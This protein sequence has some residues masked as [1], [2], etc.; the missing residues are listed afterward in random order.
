MWIFEEI[1]TL[2]GITI[3]AGMTMKV[4]PRLCSILSATAFC[5]VM[6]GRERTSKEVVLMD[7]EIMAF[8]L[9][10]FKQAVATNA[11]DLPE[12][13]RATAGA[14]EVEQEINSPDFDASIRDNGTWYLFNMA[15]IIP[16]SLFRAHLER[17][18]TVVDKYVFE[19][20]G[21][22]HVA[23][24]GDRIW[25][26]ISESKKPETKAER[27]GRYQVEHKYYLENVLIPDI[28][29]HK[30]DFKADL[31]RHM[32]DAGKGQVIKDYT[33]SEDDAF[34]DVLRRVSPTRKDREY[35]YHCHNEISEVMY[36]LS[37]DILTYDV[38]HTILDECVKSIVG[39]KTFDPVTI[40]EGLFIAYQRTFVM[41]SE[42][43]DYFTEIKEHAP[44]PLHAGKKSDR[45]NTESFMYAV[46]AGG[47]ERTK[48]LLSLS[49]KVKD[50]ERL[51]KIVQDHRNGVVYDEIQE[52]RE[53]KTTK[54]LLPAFSD[55]I[56]NRS[57]ESS[58]WPDYAIRFNIQETSVQNIDMENHITLREF[59][60]F[61]TIPIMR[62]AAVRFNTLFEYFWAK[63]DTTKW[64][65]ALYET[66]ARWQKTIT[67]ATASMKRGLDGIGAYARDALKMYFG[68]LEYVT[69]NM[70]EK[71]VAVDQKDSDA[72]LAVIA[73]FSLPKA[74]A[75]KKKEELEAL[76][77]ER[78]NK[79][80]H[81]EGDSEWSAYQMMKGIVDSP[82]VGDL[83]D[84]EIIKTVGF[85]KA[86][87]A[88]ALSMRS[89]HIAAKEKFSYAGAVKKG[90]AP[91]KEEKKQEPK[92]S[93]KKTQ[94]AKKEKKGKLPICPTLE[95]QGKCQHSDQAKHCE[96]YFHPKNFKKVDVS[97][98]TEKDD[99]SDSESDTPKQKRKPEREG[100]KTKETKESPELRLPV[101]KL[102]RVRKV[103]KTTK[104]FDIFESLKKAG[105]QR[106]GRKIVFENLADWF[107]WDEKSKHAKLRDGKSMKDAVAACLN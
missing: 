89:G 93:E 10:H 26:G 67:P 17:S 47:I 73:S 2:L 98:D 69:D 23:E 37:K 44:I 58:H 12:R 21:G 55:M 106:R 1:L 3:A 63:N 101:D 99:S 22:D 78:F 35:E 105:L 13:L 56:F 27:L 11:P 19:F 38:G 76:T 53:K 94:P 86:N 72:V 100:K 81:F 96:K 107:V 8:L 28:V 92:K 33:D 29:K 52:I 16:W 64:T 71:L 104:M 25:F 51:Y 61:K 60:P 14:L 4:L 45:T 41:Y 46:I 79:E 36:Y 31:A 103:F 80:F 32:D 83:Y 15:T 59:Q 34:T 74:K 85:A 88:V 9:P 91:K 97:S 75:L 90:L 87:G 30:K 40:L 42:I 65:I 62:H 57:M 6:Q 20:P 43:L 48:A 18:T 24:P 39:K 5:A 102:N 49:P 7:Q 95:K 84:L 70:I 77:M 82:L 68:D 50:A 66:L 54:V